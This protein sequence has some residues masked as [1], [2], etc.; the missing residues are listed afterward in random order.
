MSDR[1]KSVA[2]WNSY[3]DARK[4]KKA[5]KYPN[6]WV[7]QTRSGHV[8]I[9]DDSSGGEHIT[10]QHRGGT[11]FQMNADGSL[12]IRTSK[13]RQDI[14]FGEH[15][16]LTTG[17]KE[18]TIE[19]DSSVKTKGGS[20]QT[21]L[22]DS[23]VAIKGKS[24]ISSKSESK[25]VSEGI[26]I[27]AGWE[28]KKVNNS[29]TTQVL[30]ASTMLSKYGM[31]LGSTDSSLALGAKK[32]VGIK[33]GQQMAIEAGGKFSIKAVGGEIAIVDGK[34]YI[35][36]GQADTASDVVAMDEVPQPE[37]EETTTETA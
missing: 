22:G 21:T 7:R 14:T 5:G 20:S 9:I 35:N 28:T 3:P 1:K 29:S 6:C 2:T 32:Q 24:V 25:I 30:G 15:R 16:S 11:M 31:T 19:G 26:D 17:A 36:S 27:V 37:T 4:N 33:S 18:D 8:I 13:G 34:V 12:Q 23:T 10:I